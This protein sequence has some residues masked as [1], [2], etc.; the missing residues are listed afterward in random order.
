MEMTRQRLNESLSLSTLDECEHCAGRGRIKSLSTMSVELQ[1][2]LSG[3]LQAHETKNHDLV[4]SLS[5]ELM[6]WL[7]SQYEDLFAEMQRKHH[8]KLTF[9]PDPTFYRE[10]VVI[11]NVLTGDEIWSSL[12]LR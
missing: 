12:S 7:R 3:I 4:I 9:R 5:P 2:T 8:G 10:K 11:S 6:E 1:R